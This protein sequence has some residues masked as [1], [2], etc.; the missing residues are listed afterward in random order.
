VKQRNHEENDGGLI[1]EALIGVR[2][3]SVDRPQGVSLTQSPC[4][5]L[6]C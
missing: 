2:F 5:L 3:A 6:T 4:L 1:G